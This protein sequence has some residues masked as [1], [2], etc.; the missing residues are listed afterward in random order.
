MKNLVHHSKSNPNLQKTDVVLSVRK[1]L[2]LTSL[3]LQLCDFQLQLCNQPLCPLLCCSL[4]PLDHLHQ[5]SLTSLHGT[6]QNGEDPHAFLNVSLWVFLEAINK[7]IINECTIRS[8]WCHIRIC[9]WLIIV[10][11]P[12]FFLQ[13]SCMCSA[14]LIVI[15]SNTS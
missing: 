1:L 5:L 12:T 6:K 4:L 8:K 15:Q 11:V 3:P 10:V 9:F 13:C 14:S 2:H 7:K